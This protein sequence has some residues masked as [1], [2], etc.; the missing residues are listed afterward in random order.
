MCMQTTY[1]CVTKEGVENLPHQNDWAQQQIGDANPQ[2]TGCQP[3]CQL[4]PVTSS[5]VL[6]FQAPLV[7]KQRA[8][9]AAGQK[10][11]GRSKEDSFVILNLD[12]QANI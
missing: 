6:W 1:L 10:Q 9:R 5:L 11:Q 12:K 2:N 7:L 8:Y 3:V 4:Q